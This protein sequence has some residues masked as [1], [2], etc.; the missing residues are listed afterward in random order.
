MNTSYAKH[1]KLY[2][3]LFLPSIFGPIFYGPLKSNCNYC[4]GIYQWEIVQD[5]F[6]QKC[7][8]SELVRAVYGQGHS[9]NILLASCFEELHNIR[10]TNQHHIVLGNIH[11]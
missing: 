5:V 9:T 6:F 10:C 8:G 4:F 1:K 11:T 3:C 7:K 2:G